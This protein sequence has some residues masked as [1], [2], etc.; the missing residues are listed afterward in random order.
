MAACASSSVTR[1]ARSTPLPRTAATLTGAGR[2]R[3]IDGGASRHGW[4]CR[5]LPDACHPAGRRSH[6]PAGCWPDRVS[7]AGTARQNTTGLPPSS[8][9]QARCRTLAEMGCTVS[10]PEGLVLPIV[11]LGSTSV[12]RGEAVAGRAA[13]VEW[14]TCPAA[15]GPLRDWIVGRSAARAAATAGARVAAT[16]VARISAAPTVVLGQRGTGHEGERQRRRDD[17]RHAFLHVPP[18]E[19]LRLE[20]S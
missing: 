17:L 11:V 20:M 14:D 1:N 16:G 6:A 10:R 3:R 9:A 5:Q 12:I 19:A 4:G 8:L 18:P 2:H 13:S 7:P 15:D